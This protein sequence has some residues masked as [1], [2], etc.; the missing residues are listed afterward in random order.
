MKPF[1][2]HFFPIPSFTAFECS[3]DQ[4][5]TALS[6]IINR[7]KFGN[8]DLRRS[9]KMIQDCQELIEDIQDA[10]QEDA[11]PIEDESDEL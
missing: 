2:S 3:I 9:K 8:V 5:M 10:E 1:V 7:W 4:F 6:T 11:P